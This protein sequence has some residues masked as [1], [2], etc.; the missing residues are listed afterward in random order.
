MIQFNLLPDV[1]IKY[2]KTQHTK[3]TV[4]LIS[5]VAS[6]AAIALVSVMYVSVQIVQKKSLNNLSANIVKETKKL[7]D[8]QDLS[9]I[10]TIQNQLS[11]L[12]ALHGAKPVSSRVLGYITQVTPAV[13]VSISKLD[14][15]FTTNSI[16]ITG[17]ADSL[18]T[19]NKYADTLKF[20]TYKTATTESGKPF[21]NVVTTS[22]LSTTNVKEA[23][24]MLSFTFD[25]VLFSNTE[26]PVLT[27]PKI[28]SNRSE[29]EKPSAVFKEDTTVIPKK[30]TN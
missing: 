21:S 30:V 23:S 4:M 10:L 6:A 26:L 16:T 9:K 7:N 14:V 27:V 8:T 25:P 12:P 19:V 29:T 28:T 20:A 3:R 18:A 24:Y 17:T 15:D 13:G 1:K 22:T 5:L 11:S 2:I